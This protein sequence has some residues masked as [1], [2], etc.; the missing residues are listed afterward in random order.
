V[1]DG[2]G[3][4][5]ESVG[6]YDDWLR[7]RPALDEEAASETAGP[8]LSLHPPARKP[9]PA[10]A[11]QTSRKLSYKSSVRWRRRSANWPELPGRSKAWR[12]S[13]TSSRN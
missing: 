1:L 9:P 13:S 4:V 8:G 5:T 3:G 12:P 7:Q 11:S 6:G 2:Q 10:P